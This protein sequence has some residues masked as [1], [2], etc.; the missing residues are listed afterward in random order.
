MRVLGVHSLTHDSS[1][2]LCESGR[3]IYALEEERMS[4]FKHHPGIEVE[5]LPPFGALGWILQQANITLEEIDRIVHVGW[6]GSAFMN[7]DIIRQRYRDFANHL[8]PGHTKTT[9]VSHHR[10]HAAS[11]YYGS[12]FNKALVLAI[13]GAGDWTSTSLYIGRGTELIKVDEYPLDESLGFMY[14]RAQNCLALAIL[15]LGKVR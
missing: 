6:E 8:A 15:V 7:L 14:S 4:G 12:G 5:G 11:T 9:F 3:I 1:V 2:C 10:A 13:D